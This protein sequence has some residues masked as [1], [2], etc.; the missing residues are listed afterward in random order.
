[1]VTEEDLKRLPL[2]AIVAFAARCARRVRPLYRLPTDD[3]GAAEHEHAVERVLKMAESFAAG[4]R[5]VVAESNDTRAAAARAAGA[6]GAKYLVLD[7]PSVGATTL[8]AAALAAASAEAAS[9]SAEAAADRI[10]ATALEA[11]DR[12]ADAALSA[13]ARA[14]DELTTI[15]TAV[16][17]DY[18]RLIQLRLG[19]H[20]DLGD[21]VDPSESGPL[22]PLWPDGEPE[23]FLK[24]REI[25]VSALSSITMSA[26]AEAE[27]PG[28]LRIRAIVSEFSPE[29]EVV[30]ELVGLYRELNAYHIACGG[31]GLVIEDW[32]ILVPE[33][34]P[35]EVL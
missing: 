29:D 8:T 3:P 32:Q 9:A 33:L 4:E 2:R 7:D 24:G 26:S 22:G 34:Y 10:P 19:N 28:K 11:A 1:M 35:E 25:N 6:A 12:A 31:A 15:R 14:T 30:E 13:A 20:P 5:S 16:A 21:P 17:A 18:E 23:W 27:Q